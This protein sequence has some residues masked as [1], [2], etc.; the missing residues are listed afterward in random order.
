MLKV[1]DFT[2][3]CGGLEYPEGPFALPNGK[4]LVTELKSGDVVRVDPA[5]GSKE[6]VAKLGGS[7]NGAA[8]GPDGAIYIAN[9]GGFEWTEPLPGVWIPV[10][11]PT[12]YTT[13]SIQKISGDTIETVYTS[14]EAED[15]TTHKLCGPDDLVFDSAGGFWI[16]DWG[17]TRGRERDI[18]GICYAKAD[19]SSNKEKIFPFAGPSCPIQ[20]EPEG[21]GDS[22][23]R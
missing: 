21:R 19:G 14:F 1:S 16:S 13:G 11:E 6:R 20:D 9:S 18:T 3:V 12:D 7:P 5:D 10:D 15:G 22:N 2:A 4:V 8:I 17:K 23:T